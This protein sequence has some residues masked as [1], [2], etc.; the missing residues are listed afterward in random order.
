MKTNNKVVCNHLSWYTKLLLCKAR[1]LKTRQ[2]TCTNWPQM[3]I[4]CS[5]LIINHL[6]SQLTRDCCSPKNSSMQ[7]EE[8]NGVPWVDVA[9]GGPLI[10]VQKEQESNPGE[11]QQPFWKEAIF[12]GWGASLLN[13]LKS[14]FILYSFCM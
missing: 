6:L 10:K 3:Q 8:R 1:Q 4:M 12:R 13:Y 7:L 14:L 5:P 2:S 11:V 9:I